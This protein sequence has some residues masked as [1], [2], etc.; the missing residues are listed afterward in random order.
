MIH[1]LSLALQ[2]HSEI[3]FLKVIVPKEVLQPDIILQ[4][5]EVLM[6]M[7]VLEPHQLEG[8]HWPLEKEVLVI[9]WLQHFDS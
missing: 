9:L 3:T 7:V 2:H 1:R 5:K 8:H 6:H 4:L